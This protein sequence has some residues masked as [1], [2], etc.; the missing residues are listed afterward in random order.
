MYEKNIGFQ[1]KVGAIVSQI[2]VLQVMGSLDRRGSETMIMNIYRNIDRDKIQ[3]DF[4]IHTEKHCD[5][6][7]EIISLG[8]R[9]FSIPKYR[10]INHV[11]YVK[12]WNDFFV[13]HPEYK[14]VHGHV[15]STA[16][17]YLRIAKK[18]GIYTIAHSHNTSSGMGISAK[19]KDLFQHNI[20]YV[21]DYFMACSKE[22]GEWLF[23]KQIV[24]S[25][26]FTVLNNSIDVK[27]YLYS[28]EY[29][30]K[31]RN[32]LRLRDKFVIGNVGTFGP[33]KNHTFLIDIFK[34]IHD[35]KSD[36]V[37]LLIGDGR[38]RQEIE[39]KVHALNLSENVI[40][41][42]VR[43]DIPQLLSAMDVFAL[44]SLY[45]GLGIVA[46]EAQA[47]GLHTICSDVV[48]D[49]AAVTALFEKLSLSSAQEWANAI[50]QYS[51]GYER[52]DTYVDICNAGYDIHQSANK[53]EAFY[54]DRYK[55]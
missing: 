22:A 26:K 9:I 41:T 39:N 3:F 28:P 23:G 7:D 34:A 15:R 37:L 19:I 4:I 55:R 1:K 18:H 42:G 43:S 24:N 49:E 8:G 50:L 2:R 35:I 11:Q 27:S 54:L 53:V 32:E 16:A 25:P 44:P 38:L 29:R 46:V 30:Q 45:E 17:I 40:F 10:G 14:V 12:A 47:S 33:Q 5:Y 52:E 6:T 36:S 21:A 31:I 20:R 13:S 48:P 51:N